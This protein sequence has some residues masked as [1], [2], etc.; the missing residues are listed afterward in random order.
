MTSK[1]DYYEV[2][3]VSRQASQVEIKT[4]FRRLARKYHPD[5]SHEPDAEARFKEINEAYEVLGDPEKRAQ[6]DRFGHAGV[7]GPNGF[8]GGAG[9]GADFVDFND[10]FEGLFGFGRRSGGRRS[11]HAPRQG[12]DIGAE[13]TLTF[14]EAAHGV[15]KVVKVRRYETCPRCH[16]TGAEPG[17]SPVTCPQ[18]H[19]RGEVRQV[20]QSFLG[21]FI[22]VTT[23]PR[24]GGSGEVIPTPCSTCHGRK[25]IERA[26]EIEVNIPA[27]VD[28][29]MRVR[30]GGEG[31]TGLNGGPAGDLYVTVHVKPHPIFKRA[32]NDVLLDLPINL[33]QAALGDEVE[34][35][36]LDG[37]EKL[38]I[39]AGTQ[40][41][42]VFRLPNKG[43]PDV[44]N[45]R[46]RGDERI[47]VR[48]ITPRNL[49]AQQ[50]KLL[51]ELG[52]TLG[53]TPQPDDRN[54]LERMLDAIG[55]SH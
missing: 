35:L 18:C 4:S 6:Y 13:V 33:A 7:S 53:R 11:P 36:T 17:T 55:A 39:P 46:R 5:V 1:R 2:L 23:C 45:Q 37:K 38:R 16:G 44:H 15:K 30:L 49:T 8:G 32:N 48:V 28:E 31:N 14:D 12:S 21:R 3:G 29:G 27:G 50:K 54:F 47:T 40:S 41:G 26:R 10:L 22:N 24:C 19:G 43:F 34:V 42:H 25:V 51:Q 20:Q 9:F 52:E